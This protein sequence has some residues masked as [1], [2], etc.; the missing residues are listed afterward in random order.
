MFSEAALI[1]ALVTAQ[2]L[3]ELWH[4]ARNEQRLRA[5]GAY[6]VGAAHYPLMVA[7]HAAWLVGLWVLAWDRPA[8]WWLVGV[9]AAL[10]VARYWIIASLGERWTTRI[11]VPPG[12]PLVKSGPYALLRHPNYAVV[13]LE[14]ALLPLVFGLFTYAAIFSTA[15]ALL[16]AW[17]M[18]VEDRALGNAP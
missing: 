18:H 7:L 6:E 14:I 17:R 16:L 4:S 5:Q 3:A 15:N 12:A 8:N 2:R 9:Y 1:L 13:A 11:L 10:Q